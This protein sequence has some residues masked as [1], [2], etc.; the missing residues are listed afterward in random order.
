MA[1]HRLTQLYALAKDRWLHR[2]G[3]STVRL[4]YFWVKSRFST[5]VR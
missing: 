3:L 5:T 4:R 1:G 2:R